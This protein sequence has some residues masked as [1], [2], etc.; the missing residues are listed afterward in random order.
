[1][2]LH[3]FTLNVLLAIADVWIFHQNSMG[4]SMLSSDSC[5]IPAKHIEEMIN[6]PYMNFIWSEH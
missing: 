2:T 4:V 1:M 5:Y 3:K 6:V